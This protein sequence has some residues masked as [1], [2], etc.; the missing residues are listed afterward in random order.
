MAIHQT[1][2]FFSY[3]GHQNISESH[4]NH[5]SLRGAASFSRLHFEKIAVRNSLLASLP[6]RSGLDID[7]SIG[8]WFHVFTLLHSMHGL[9]ELRMDMYSDVFETGYRDREES[10]YRRAVW[11]RIKGEL[12]SLRSKN[13]GLKVLRITMRVTG[14]MSE[15]KRLEDEQDI[16]R[17]VEF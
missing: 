6:P 8:T 2:S 16:V 10:S 15:L 13:G 5:H 1:P 14:K 17:F 11:E 3:Y 7:A 12:D 9:R 4:L